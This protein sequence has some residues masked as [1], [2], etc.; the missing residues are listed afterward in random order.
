MSIR[1]IAGEVSA[2]GGFGFRLHP[3][4]P[5]ISESSAS[6]QV[7]RLT[8]PPIDNATWTIAPSGGSKPERE[9]TIRVPAGKRYSNVSGT[10][11]GPALLFACFVIGVKR[12]MKNVDSP[13]LSRV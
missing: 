9:T 8:V 1:A 10:D 5:S 12:I 6:P 7:F 11:P 4:Q 13:I 2:G 3:S